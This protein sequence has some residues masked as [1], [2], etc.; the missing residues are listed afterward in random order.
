MKC[1]ICI[2]YIP[3]YHQIWCK[4]LYDAPVAARGKYGEWK[5]FDGR[6]IITALKVTP[7]YSKYCYWRIYFSTCAKTIVILS[8]QNLC[9]YNISST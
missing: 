8:I 2:S 1:K 6:K 9:V 7:L 3:R 5:T 4:N